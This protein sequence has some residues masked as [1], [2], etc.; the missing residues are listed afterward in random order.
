MTFKF[1]F[2]VLNTKLP[3]NEMLVSKDFITV[4]NNNLISLDLESNAFPS[5]LALLK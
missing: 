1:E 5:Q 2:L 3:E 4:K